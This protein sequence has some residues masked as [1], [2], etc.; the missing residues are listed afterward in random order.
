MYLGFFRLWYLKILVSDS[1][2]GSYDQLCDYLM[3]MISP[4]MFVAT[5]DATGYLL[6]CCYWVLANFY[7]FGWKDLDSFG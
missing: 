2:I 3:K 7:C 5:V 6:V 4:G 1:E